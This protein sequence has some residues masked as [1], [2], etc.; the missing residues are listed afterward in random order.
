MAGYTL[1]KH[2][3]RLLLKRFHPIEILRKRAAEEAADF[4]EAHAPGAV[5]FRNREE[6]HDY[7][8]RR[9]PD[10]GL[11]LEFGVFRGKSLNR[12]AKN[13][14]RRKDP[15]TIYGFDAFKGLEEDWGGTRHGK[16]AFDQQGKTP[17]VRSNA[18][19]VVGWVQDTLGPFLESHPGPIAMLNIDTDT[20]GP[21]AHIIDLT[22]SRLH[23]GALL[24]LCSL[25]DGCCVCCRCCCHRC[26]CCW[27]VFCCCCHFPLLPPILFEKKDQL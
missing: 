4:L 1:T 11:L 20:Y 18:K 10:E 3:D 16:G 26:C 19:L 24:L 14:S 15:R 7:A 22:A 2:L 12:F 17:N 6:L 13:L 27:H 9:V 23:K 21:A 5:F 25:F 8:I